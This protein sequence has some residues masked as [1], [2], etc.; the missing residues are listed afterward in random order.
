[1]II[2]NIK[3]SIIITINNNNPKSISLWIPSY[4]LLE[5]RRY[6]HQPAVILP[7][8]RYWWIHRV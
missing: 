7:D 3:K 1:M 2:I 5:G 4:F 8:P 6:S